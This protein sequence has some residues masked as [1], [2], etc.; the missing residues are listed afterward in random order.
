[1]IN[2]KQL[3]A[4]SSAAFILALTPIQVSSATDYGY[5]YG[6]NSHHGH[7][8]HHNYR[9]H[10]G[11]SRHY[12][13]NHYRKHNNH[14]YYP[15]YSYGYS[16]NYSGNASNYSSGKDCRPTHKYQY[17]E[18][19]NEIRINGTLCYN[20]YGNAYIVPGSRYVADSYH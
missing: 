3:L 7:G 2:I 4:L 6:S 1:M 8:K 5:S 14:S 15:S 11:N 16:S 20:S 13:S 9:H 17:D 10:Y 19:G 18:H 12:N